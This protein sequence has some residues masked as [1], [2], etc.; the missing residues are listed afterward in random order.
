[1][2][3][4]TPYKTKNVFIVCVTVLI[5]LTML[6]WFGNLFDG[7]NQRTQRNHDNACRTIESEMLRTFCL[8]GH[9]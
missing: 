2:A 3:Y 1:M 9:S 5:A 6:V 4:D 7:R 8:G